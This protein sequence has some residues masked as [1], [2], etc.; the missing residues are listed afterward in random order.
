META[1]VRATRNARLRQHHYRW[2]QIKGKW[3]LIGPDGW[4]TTVEEAEQ[5]IQNHEN[6]PPVAPSQWA[7]T[8][9]AQNP[10]ILDSETTGLEPAVHEIIDLALVELDGTVAFNSLIQC[11]NELPAEATRVHHITQEMLRDQPT[12]PEIWP[13]L[14]PLLTRP[15][16]IYNAPFDILM[17]AYQAVSYDIRMQ[18]P[19]AHCLMIQYI[20]YC[21]DHYM[22]DH[23]LEGACH[24]FKVEPGTHRAL[25]DAQAARQVLL[26]MAEVE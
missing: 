24:H 19:Q 23:S 8:M 4:R 12:F 14:S 9:I 18:R 1:T 2:K 5:A 22:L 11:R 13:Q 10:L 21:L 25:A 16:V 6:Q 20:N 15:L 26:S 7:R 3:F 17:L